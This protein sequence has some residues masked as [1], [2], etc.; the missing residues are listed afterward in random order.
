MVRTTIVN[1]VAT[2]SLNQK[3][4]LYE[5]EKFKEIRH[6]PEIYGGR[7]AYFKRQTMKGRV[8]IFSTGKMISVGTKSEKEAATELQ[9]TKKFLVQKKLIEP[10]RLQPKTQN[11][12]TMAE[13]ERD[14]NLEE[15]AKKCGMI[16]EPEQFPGGILRINDPYKATVLVFASGKI[17]IA[18]LKNSDHIEPMVQELTNLLK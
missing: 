5:L 13:M 12:V 14:L 3:I 7:V 10:I 11:I 4:D 18:G 2:T 6:D 8:T 15:L 17:I 1:V 9:L 16:Y